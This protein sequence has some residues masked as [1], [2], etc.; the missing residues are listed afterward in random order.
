[1]KD[2]SYVPDV[3]RQYIV[4]IHFSSNCHKDFYKKSSHRKC[5][6]KNVFLKILQNSQENTRF[7]VSFPIGLLLHFTGKN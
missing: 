2:K 3:A 4:F 5:S 1:M 6:I 7:G